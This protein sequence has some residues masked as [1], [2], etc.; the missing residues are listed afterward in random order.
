MFQNRVPRRTCGIKKEEGR[1]EERR[2]ENAASCGGSHFV[3]LPNNFG[4]VKSKAIG[5]SGMWRTAE[6]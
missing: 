1:G 4:I 2:G 6:G 3:F 5:C